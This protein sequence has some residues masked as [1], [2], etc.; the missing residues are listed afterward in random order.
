MDDSDFTFC[1]T[2]LGELSI[3]NASGYYHPQS[4]AEKEATEWFASLNLNENTPILY[5]YGIGLGYYYKAAKKW[6]KSKK[7]HC[8]IF[9]EDDQALLARFFHTKLATTLLLDTQ[10]HIYFLSD[11]QVKRNSV[12]DRVQW[13]YG[14]CNIATS[15]LGSYAKEPSHAAAFVDIQNRLQSDVARVQLVVSEYLNHGVNFY[16]NFYNNLQELPKASLANQFFGKFKNVPAILCGAGPSLGKNSHLLK[17]LSNKALIFAGGSALNALSTQ[18][19]LPHFGGGIDPFHIQAER[20]S[21]TCHLQVPLFYHS[22]LCHEGLRMLTGPRLYVAN[23]DEYPILE[24]VEEELGI[25][26]YDGKEE[27]QINS[28]HNVVNFLT[29]IAKALG[30]NPIIFIGMDLAYTNMQSYAQGVINNTDVNVENLLNANAPIDVPQQR[31][32]IYGNT[33]YTDW[34][35]IWESQWLT[36]FVQ[37]N[38][39]LTVINATEGGMGY[40]NVPNMMLQEVIEKYLTKDYDFNPKINEIITQSSLSYLTHANVQNILQQLK[41]SFQRSSVLIEKIVQGL[42]KMTNY[43]KKHG[44]ILESLQTECALVKFELEEEVAYRYIM[45]D[46]YTV[47]YKMGRG[48]MEKIPKT[49]TQQLQQ[50]KWEIQAYLYLYETTQVHLS[51]I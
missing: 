3:A 19:P 12:F 29:S 31:E 6:L 10:V 48:L 46:F 34:R 24:W 23:C 47:I 17:Q 33:V 41:E 36:D 38:S 43:L 5:V 35:W 22:R 44:K 25:K 21:Q 7:G 26:N 4:G 13:D 11:D 30:C 18:E 39:S 32:D 16:E 28:G 9:L 42:G 20:I 50:I 51:L 37:K 40:K 14:N 2:E 27:E 15:L 8:L 49:A 1:Q 45:K